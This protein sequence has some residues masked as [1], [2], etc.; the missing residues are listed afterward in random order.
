M[1]SERE[2]QEWIDWFAA[3]LRE[4]EE[5][6]LK[7]TGKPHVADPVL[8]AFLKMNNELVKPAVDAAVVELA[9]HGAR[10]SFLSGD[11]IINLI[12][13]AYVARGLLLELLASKGSREFAPCLQ[14]PKFIRWILIDLWQMGGA[15]H[16]AALTNRYLAEH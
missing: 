13:R 7:K 4:C 8:V 1:I 3:L 6:Y 9:D 2:L 12:Q 5:I 11:E 14:R 16:L 15:A 10:P